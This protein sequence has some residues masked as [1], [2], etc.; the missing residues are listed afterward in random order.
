M[1]SPIIKII[2]VGL[3]SIFLEGTKEEILKTKI[4]LKVRMM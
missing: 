4:K 2:L 1:P 3:A